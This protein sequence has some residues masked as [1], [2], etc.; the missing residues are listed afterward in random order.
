M[1]LSFLEEGDGTAPDLFIGLDLAL[2]S[3]GVV[4][5]AVAA[6]VEMMFS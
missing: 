1:V 3:P 2:A 4:S 5:G 6:T